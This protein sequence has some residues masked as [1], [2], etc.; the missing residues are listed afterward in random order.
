MYMG[1]VSQERMEVKVYQKKF[2]KDFL[3]SKFCFPSLLSGFY[4]LGE[5]EIFLD[6]PPVI[7]FLFF[8]YPKPSLHFKFYI[9]NYK[10]TPSAVRLGIYLTYPLISQR[11]ALDITLKDQAQHLALEWKVVC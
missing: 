10:L 8:L 4:M 11:S 6:V 5:C 1:V 7:L 9:S 2:F 3:F